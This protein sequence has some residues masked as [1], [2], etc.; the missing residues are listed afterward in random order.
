MLDDWH[1]AQDM[2]VEMRA[3]R[4][5]MT[6][7]AYDCLHLKCEG[8]RARCSKGRALTTAKDGSIAMES[9]VRGYTPKV[10]LKCP[11]YNGEESPE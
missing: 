11:D 2:L 4:R 8:K 5:R 6:R 10:C 3:G 7:I 9:V 1:E